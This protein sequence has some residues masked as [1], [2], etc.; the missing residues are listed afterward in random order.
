MKTVSY[1]TETTGLD[2]RKGQIFSFST[3][4]PE[5]SLEVHRFDGP[6]GRRRKS[7][8]TLEEIWSQ[9]LLAKVCHNAKFD[10]PF[11]QRF[12]GEWEDLWTTHTIH[13]TMVM[14]HLLQN[15]H[16]SHALK[17]LAWELSG[18]PKDDETAIKPYTRGG[19][20]Y[21]DVPEVL[22]DAY[23]KGDA[24]RTMLLHLFFWPKI[25]KD[26]AARTT[27]LLERIFGALGG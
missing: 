12:L 17:D 3:C 4:T 21:A 7:L 9:P 22:M 8:H 14:S 20:S 23:Q 18:Y 2:R 24:E 11:T 15:H 16:P 6:P 27:E 25:R 10:I 1:D 19:A 13:D 5:G 26:P